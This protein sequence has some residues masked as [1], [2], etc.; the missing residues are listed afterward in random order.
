MP[1]PGHHSNRFSQPEDR[2]YCEAVFLARLIEAE[3][4][5]PYYGI[6]INTGMGNPTAPLIAASG[7]QTGF[8]RQVGRRKNFYRPYKEVRPLSLYPRL[9]LPLAHSPLPEP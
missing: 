7:R 1:W 2:T 9:R 5:S 8:T 3:I 6:L 4:V